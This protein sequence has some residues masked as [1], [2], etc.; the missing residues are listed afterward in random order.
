MKIIIDDVVLDEL[1]DY[2][3]S[4]DGINSVDIN[5][6]GWQSEINIDFDKR[7]TPL[8]IMKHIDL[9]L[10]NKFSKLVSFDKKIKGNFK[11][12]KYIVDDM[13]CEYC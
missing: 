5:I 6:Y 1:K 11:K 10:D 8:I 9:F 7:I 4:Q 13:C 2:L 12:I 3:L